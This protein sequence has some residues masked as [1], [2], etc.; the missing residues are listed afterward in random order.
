MLFAKPVNIAQAVAKCEREGGQLATAADGVTLTFFVDIMYGEYYR[1][2]HAGT[3]SAMISAL[4]DPTKN[5]VMIK[6]DSIQPESPCVSVGVP[7]C[8]L[9]DA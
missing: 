2:L 3:E 9:N 6:S 5:C 7:I 1:G 8:R 4:S